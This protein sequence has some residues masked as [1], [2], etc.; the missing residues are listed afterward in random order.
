MGALDDR[1]LARGLAA[2]RIGLGVVLLAAPGLTRHW[3]TD[4]GRK[5]AMK[6]MA[7]GLA[8]RDLALGVGTLRAME[9]NDGS[10]RAWLE[11]GMIADAA[12]AL[13]LVLAWRHLPRGVRAIATG[14]AVGAALLGRR[15]TLTAG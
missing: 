12:D 1:M 9:R 2:S 7:R 10:A 8:G 4:D 6:A 3:L 13:G 5:P 15:L 14:S 11:A